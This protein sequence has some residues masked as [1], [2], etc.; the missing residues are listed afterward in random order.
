M[1]LREELREPFKDADLAFGGCE[2]LALLVDC[3]VIAGKTI[4]EAEIGIFIIPHV[5]W[6]DSGRI[7]RCL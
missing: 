3:R 5:K 2:H 7:V 6:S 4:L 1:T